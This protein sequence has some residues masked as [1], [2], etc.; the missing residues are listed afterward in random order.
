MEEKHGNRWNYE[1]DNIIINH[2]SKPNLRYWGYHMKK[3]KL[4][5]S[6]EHC[7]RYFIQN[8][9]YKA[10]LIK[11]PN[12]KYDTFLRHLKEL[13]QKRLVRT[14]PKMSV[15]VRNKHVVLARLYCL[16]QRGKWKQHTI[17]RNQFFIKNY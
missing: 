2:M 13:C 3:A 9:L 15:W 10:V 6:R 16:T 11:Y 1:I 4:S 7:S 17:Q 12:T 8:D 14:F 5:L